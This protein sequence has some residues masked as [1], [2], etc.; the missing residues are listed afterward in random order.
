MADTMTG[1]EIKSAI[2]SDGHRQT[3]ARTE[4]NIMVGAIMYARENM[5]AADIPNS[6]RKVDGGGPDRKVV[7]AF[8]EVLHMVKVK[9]VMDI[10]FNEGAVLE[11]RLE[12]EQN[13]NRRKIPVQPKIV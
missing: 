7:V 1:E 8:V 9:V 4:T 12:S 11:D 13:C 6:H 3:M 5:E 10:V 2:G